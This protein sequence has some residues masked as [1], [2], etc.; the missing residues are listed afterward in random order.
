MLVFLFL[1][2]LNLGTQIRCPQKWYTNLKWALGQPLVWVTTK[3]MIYLI[4]VK[5]KKKNI[6]IN[7][8]LR[9]GDTPLTI[10][11]LPP[12]TT[13]IIESKRTTVAS[14][15]FMILSK[16]T[17]ILKI[18]KNILVIYDSGLLQKKKDVLWLFVERTI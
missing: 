5:W 4:T 9:L 3:G 13:S 10:T 6:K 1:P 18:K 7:S 8:N 12:T 11:K 15:F 17:K 14:N 16:A 2:F